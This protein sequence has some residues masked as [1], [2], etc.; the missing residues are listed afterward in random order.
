MRALIIA[1]VV[2]VALAPTAHATSQDDQYLAALTSRNIGGTPEQLIAYGH[3]ACDGYGTPE[4]ADQAQ[5]LEAI[6]YT[7]IQAA[8][9]VATA[10]LAYCPEKLPPQGPTSP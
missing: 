9:I 7:D 10:V 4:V 8:D 3:T 5:S 2:S 6:G 1:A